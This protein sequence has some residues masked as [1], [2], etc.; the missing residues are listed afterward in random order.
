ML[1]VYNIQ[2]PAKRIPNIFYIKKNRPLCYEPP[3][4]R[5]ATKKATLSPNRSGV[6]SGRDQAG[7]DGLRCNS[8]ALQPAGPLG[9]AST[10]LWEGHRLSQLGF[11][12]DCR[13]AQRTAAVA[14]FS[15]TRAA[16]MSHVLPSIKAAGLW[17]SLAARWATG[18]GEETSVEAECGDTCLLHK[19]TDSADKPRNYMWHVHVSHHAGLWRVLLN[20]GRLFT[21][22]VT[23]LSWRLKKMTDVWFLSSLIC[24]CCRMSWAGGGY[25]LQANHDN[26]FADE[27]VHIQHHV[28]WATW[29]KS[30]T[31]HL[32]QT[33]LSTQLQWRLNQQ[34]WQPQSLASVVVFW[35]R[36]RCNA[37]GLD[38]RGKKLFNYLLVTHM[39]AFA[40]NCN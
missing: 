38:W 10:Q 11:L 24:D 12:S 35:A 16:E 3:V 2:S 29:F 31:G 37:P 25:V 15:P 30:M 27:T 4:G 5:S 23:F 34:T 1:C 26:R 7:S 14:A 20:T 21:F 36:R 32:R 39:L 33:I 22:W 28:H 13:L 40:A 8:L 6:R 9:G 17:I 18:W 19:Q